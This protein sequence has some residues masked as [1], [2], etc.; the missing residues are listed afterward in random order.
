M[1]RPWFPFPLS[2]TMAAAPM[3]RLFG[4]LLLLCLACVPGRIQGDEPAEAGVEHFEKKIRPVLVQHCYPC[5]SSA[6][7]EVKGGLRLDTREGLRQGGD[8]GP[9]VEPGDPATSLLIKAV[10]Y[11]DENLRMP[12]TAKLS[13]LEIADLE[14]WV[15]MGVPD[16]RTKT[17]GAT[18][19][20][21]L[22]KGRDFWSFRPVRDP[23]LPSVKTPAWALNAV[24][25]FV[26]H[27]LEEHG[28]A[29]LESAD[30]RTLIRRASY[31][32]TGLP[33]SP[34]EI[35]AFLVDDSPDAFARVVDRMLASP[36]YGERW[37]RHWL[38]VVRY[39]DTAGDN[40]DYPVPQLYKY[41]NWVIDAIGDDKPYDQFL[42]EQLAGDLMPGTGVQDRYNKIIGTGY[43]ANARRFG[44][45]TEPRY[46]WH[47][48]I[49]D[50][51][52]N[53][54]RAFLGLTINCARCHDHKFDP[55]SNEDYYALYGFFQSTRYPWPGI[56]VDKAPRDLV[57]LACEEEVAAV[58]K[59][60][61][62]KLA[63]FDAQLKQ[64][65]EEKASADQALL[66][67]EKAPDD[68]HPVDRVAEITKR[69]ESLVNQR[70][71]VQN[72]RDKYAKQPL[73]FETAYA[74]ADANDADKKK[75]GNAC[76]QI[77]GDP[78]RLGKEV[79][80]R[81][82]EVL[83]GMRLA[84]D[85]QG[86]GRL[87]L[88]RWIASPA[89]PLTARVMVNRI[90][91]YH[92]GKGIVQT[93]NDFGKQGRPPTHP[94]LLDYLAQRFVDSGWSIKSVH[95]L[96]MLSRTY[97][98]SSRDDAANNRLDLDNDYLWHYQR[99][100]L[101][102]ESIRDTLLSVSGDLDR[103][104]GGPHPF[105]DQAK[106]EF[107]EH[108]VFKDVYET[109]RRSVYLMTQRLY[110]HPFL[111]LFDGAG[112]NAST[113][114]RIT[115]TTPLQALY[116]M[117]D[118]FIHAQARKFAARLLAQRPDDAQRIDWAY[119]LMMGR[120]AGAEERTAAQAYLAQV[121]AKLQSTGAPPNQQTGQQTD[122][123]TAQAWESLARALFM[124]SE[125]VYV[126]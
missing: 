60:R 120:P 15:K 102:A 71:S 56:E 14:R 111:G 84:P 80:R 64:L 18:E 73:P 43:L 52:D 17:E 46:P 61:L 42:R 108:N 79:P 28:L 57:P 54:G 126:N 121:R 11:E 116:L 101:D 5:H 66:Q 75:V 88:A 96:I 55:V 109:N 115:S 99:S 22:A 37:G 1:Y 23:P 113:D 90:W 98:L 39:S 13:A 117:N 50:T 44:S 48:T 94:E 12:P 29:P 82:P 67:T 119:R 114:R 20:I 31:D 24:D 76:V 100:R 45:E 47:L 63:A 38:D 6:A 83:G 58:L 123:Q 74:V 87:E 9:A 10:R 86:S 53:L 65:D 107:T 81:F 93:P 40:S 59:E 97:Q 69:I 7:K 125:F 4:R 122:Q 85:V 51:I 2:D 89:N 26:L 104:M 95:R 106:W 19:E 3:R 32:L 77:K 72:E 78:Q 103:S 8:S 118:P 70:R 91:H 33:P 62:P 110:R 68:D 49:E 36:A 35:D 92:F 21:D 25:Q 30:K 27:K 124:S 34:E 16:P 112:T 105:P 41:R